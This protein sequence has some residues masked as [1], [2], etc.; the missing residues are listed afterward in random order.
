MNDYGEQKYLFTFSLLFSRENIVS[1]L[2]RLKTK[3]IALFTSMMKTLFCNLHY[4]STDVK[5]AM[6]SSP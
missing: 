4:A 6:V 2:N 3:F 1:T 5:I